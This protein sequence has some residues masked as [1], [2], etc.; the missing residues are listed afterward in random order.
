MAFRVCFWEGRWENGLRKWANE[1]V[2][3][4]RGGRMEVPLSVVFAA[5]LGSVVMGGV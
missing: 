4:S 1:E 2:Y 5:W 3:G